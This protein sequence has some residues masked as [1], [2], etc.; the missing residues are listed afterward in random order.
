MLAKSSHNSK[1]LK[2]LN[3][4]KQDGSAATRW[5]KMVERQQECFLL[6][7]Y[8]H[9]VIHTFISKFIVGAKVTCTYGIERA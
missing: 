7:K 5:Y 9:A 8:R 4:R 1:C 2:P 6:L 3:E